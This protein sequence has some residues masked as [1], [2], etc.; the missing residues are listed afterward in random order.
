MKKKLISMLL[1]IVMVCTMIPAT[2]FAATDEAA[3]AAEALYELGLFK[4]TGTNEDGT[5]IF[6]LDKTPSR[7]QAIIMLIRLL[8]KE[9]EALAGT[10]TIPFTDVPDNMKPYIGYAY[11]NGLTNG[12]TAT[13]YCGTNPI[14]ANQYI[15]FVLRALG[16]ES[17]K[18]FEV[19]SSWEL[20]DTIGLTDGYYNASTTQ[21]LRG[22]I[23]VISEN[24]LNVK[25]KAGTAV[26]LDKLVSSAAVDANAAKVYRS[27]PVRV[28]S[29]QLSDT[30]WT[31]RKGE[32]KQL[33]ASVFPENASDKKVTWESS[34]SSVATVSS[35]GKVQ[36]KQN[37]TAKIIAK[38]SNGRSAVCEI[39]VKAIEITSITLSKTSLNLTEGKSAT[40]TT[41]LAPS[42]AEDKSVVWSS[43]N[44][45]VA[46][47]SNGKITAVKQGSAVITV[48]A[49]NGVSAT[50]TVTVQPVKWYYENMYRVGT[51]IPAGDYYAVTTDSRYGGY[52]CKYTNSS[53]DDI[54]DNDNFDTFTFFRAYEGQYLNLSRCKITAIE[55]AP[56]ASPNS[57]GSYGEGMYRVGIDIPAGEYKFTSTDKYGGYFCAYTDIT[58]EDI[59]E[60]DNFDYSTYYT[61]KAGQYLK[62]NCATAVYLGSDSVGGGTSSGGTS[63]S[64][65]SSS[66][67]G[68]SAY[69][70]DF[71]SVPDFGA[72]F[73]VSPTYESDGS[74]IYKSSDVYAA[75]GSNALS[76]YI[77]ALQNCGFRAQIS[78]G[79]DSSSTVIYKNASSGLTV[80]I[81]VTMISSGEHIGISI[82]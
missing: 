19:G 71:D 36:A 38:T 31:M 74:Y 54:E 56:V 55:N 78:Y 3:E 63:S 10:W 49:S 4:G 21:F 1:A 32:S 12:Y 17:G 18:D 39:S 14:R 40:L 69:Y 9:E 2:A 11:T 65:G 66:S 33:T 60:N 34:D 6:D 72:M 22:D 62:I 37:G 29:V 77:R 64:G 27:N 41:T 42:N 16:Y 23:A 51:D 73:G 59:E 57:D 8:G 47:V 5:P 68:T 80:S 79:G 58:Y 75:A 13:T 15:A 46:T 70:D 61:V 48:A 24:A 25:D 67:T 43:S 82:Y 28:K 52:Y 7:N 26:L 53:R 45:S 20:S 30:S 76:Q 50:C 35:T 81:S 44:P